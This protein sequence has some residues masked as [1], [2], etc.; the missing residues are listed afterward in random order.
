MLKIKIDYSSNFTPNEI[1]K[2]IRCEGN[3][4]KIVNSTLF[5]Q[6][7]LRADF[8]GETSQWKNKTNLEIF[9]HFMSGAE[10]LQPEIDNEADIFIDIFNPK[11]FQSVVGYTYSY[12]VMQWINRKFFWALS[13]AGVEGNLAHEWGHK[14]GFDHD[15]KATARR[16]FSIC[17]QL[18]KIINFCHAVIIDGQEFPVAA[19]KAYVPKWKRLLFFWRY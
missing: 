12:T 11:P 9:E 3:L 13:D 8:S 18:N 2:L 19:V 5:K 6:E 4:E 14:L 16:P 7:F 15:F 10:T 17:Y 1:S